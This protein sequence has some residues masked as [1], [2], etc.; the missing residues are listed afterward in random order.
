MKRGI[1]ELITFWQN[2]DKLKDEGNLG[3][4]FEALNTAGDQM[5]CVEEG[6]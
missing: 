4:Y 3:N 5:R 6:L 1:K 2:N